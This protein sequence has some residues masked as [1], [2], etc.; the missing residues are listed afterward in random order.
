[1]KVCLLKKSAASPGAK[2]ITMTVVSPQGNCSAKSVKTPA[3]VNDSS[4]IKPSTSRLTFKQMIQ[5]GKSDDR[6]VSMKSM[7]LPETNDHTPRSLRQLQ[8]DNHT[9]QFQEAICRLMAKARQRDSRSSKNQAS[10]E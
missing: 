9:A 5:D 4:V 10:R 3:F 7:D 1:M 6:P 2:D 8:A